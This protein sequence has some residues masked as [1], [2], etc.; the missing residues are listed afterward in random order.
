MIS[1]SIRPQFKHQSSPYDSDIHS[2]IIATTMFIILYVV[3]LSV[4]SIKTM[5]KKIFF[6]LS[7]FKWNKNKVNGKFVRIVIIS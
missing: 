7:K 1:M 2:F 5:E 3:F 6:L 4:S